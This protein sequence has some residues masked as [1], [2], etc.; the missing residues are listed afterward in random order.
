MTKKVLSLLILL[1]IIA[2]L[3]QADAYLD[4]GTGSMLIQGLIAVG[5]GAAYTL[6]LYWNQVKGFFTRDKNGSNDV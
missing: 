3:N 2:D 1:I 6:K 5:V 4:P